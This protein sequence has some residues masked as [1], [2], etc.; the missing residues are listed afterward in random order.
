MNDI[1][2][3][4]QCYK[5]KKALIYV[6][7]SFKKKY[8]DSNIILVNDGG[9]DFEDIANHYKCDY[10]YEKKSQTTKNA[11]YFTE[12]SIFDY[13]NNIRKHILTIN[14][15]YVILLE[16]DVVVVKKITMN[17]LKY[18]INGCN[19]STRIEDSVFNLIKKE[20]IELIDRFYGG[21]GGCILNT[22][23]F[24][25]VFHNKEKLKLDLNEFILNSKTYASDY[26]L[27]YLCLRN[28]GT[29]GQYPGFCETWHQDYQ[30]RILNNSIEVLHQFKNLYD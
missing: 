9:D 2:A 15:P 23:F 3:Y 13:I 25:K 24:K 11:L 4:Y 20:N 10:F 5:N 7:D 19:H 14:T 12:N 29:I 22:N 27:S 17:D 30:N 28:N 1:T 26:I 18:D 21:C 16:D 8:P 6:L